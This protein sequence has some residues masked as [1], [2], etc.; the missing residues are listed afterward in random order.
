MQE[1]AFW[2]Q[3]ISAFAP[4]WSAVIDPSVTAGESTLA[5]VDTYVYAMDAKTG[6]VAVAGLANRRAEE[7]IRKTRSLPDAMLTGGPAAIELIAAMDA[8]GAEAGDE[9]TRKA[10]VGA[11]VALASTSTIDVVMSR[12]GNLAG[13][14]MYLV[15]TPARGA[16]FGRPV[17]RSATTA[18]VLHMQEVLATAANAIALDVGR[19]DSSVG[20]QIAQAGGLVL[21]E[22][23]ALLVR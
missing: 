14:L 18:G 4:G 8:K 21:C 13:H 2:N 23:L 22:K 3:F 16:K 5:E 1:A 12:Q 15:Y 7:V 19:K 17:F 11:L 9:L 6:W 20:R 10:T